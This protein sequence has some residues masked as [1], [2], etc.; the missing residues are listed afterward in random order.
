MAASL[1]KDAVPHVR[2]A[3][4]L[5]DLAVTGGAG[6]SLGEVVQPTV[7][8]GWRGV[9]GEVGA[10]G[11]EVFDHA[12]EGIVA[13]V[14]GAGVGVEWFDAAGQGA[15]AGQHD[16]GG[17]G[18]PGAGGGAVGRGGQVLGEEGGRV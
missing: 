3:G 8:L 10:Q 2:V 6:Q 16:V 1:T 15:G 5:S 13:D 18:H 17:G 11:N 14:N 7:E 9:E 4:R 12:V